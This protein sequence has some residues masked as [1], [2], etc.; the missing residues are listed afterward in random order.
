VEFFVGVEVAVRLGSG[1]IDANTVGVPFCP[2]QEVRI[3][4]TT[5][6]IKNVFF[7]SL[8]CKEPAN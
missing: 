6:E 1:V 5:A 3:M 4:Q 8:I 2:L 7:M